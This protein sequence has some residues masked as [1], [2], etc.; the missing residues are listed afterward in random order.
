MKKTCEEWKEEE[1]QGKKGNS[2]FEN[3]EFKKKIEEF[4]TGG[5][6]LAKAQR[7]KS[8][9]QA[10]KIA[11]EALQ[12]IY[13][14]LKNC[15]ID[16]REL[17][18]KKFD[19]LF[20]VRQIVMAAGLGSRF[21]LLIH[22]ATA[23]GGIGKTNIELAMEGAFQSPTIVPVVIVNPKILGLV[24]KGEYLEGYSTETG[25]F[26]I[27]KDVL[28]QL[29]YQ[30][31]NSKSE[32][33]DKDLLIRYFGRANILLCYL[34][35]PLGP[36]GDLLEIAKI[37]C[38]KGYETPY[39]EVVYGEMSP[40]VLPEYTNTSLVAYLK[41]LSGDYVA[42]V[43]AKESQG[44]IE[45][46]GNFAF[47]NST[48]AAHED[49]ERIPHGYKNE[50][51]F[52]RVLEQHG[53]NYKIVKEKLTIMQKQHHQGKLDKQQLRE[54]V[55][56]L[57]ENYPYFVISDEGELFCQEKLKEV[58]DKLETW[59]EMSNEEKEYIKRNYAVTE[60]CTETGVTADLMI[61]ANVAIFETEVLAGFY[62][63]LMKE[64][65]EQGYKEYHESL[66]KGE[67]V[68]NRK[69][70]R[71]WGVD[72]KSGRSKAI[73]WSFSRIIKEWWSREHPGE[74]A[75]VALID[76][77]GAPSSIK[78]A[79]RQFEFTNRYNMVY[80]KKK[81][82]G[83][84]DSKWSQILL[85]RKKLEI[86]LCNVL[87]N[88]I[89]DYRKLINDLFLISKNNVK[90]QIIVLSTLK[91]IEE[92]LQNYNGKYPPEVIQGIHL[93][94]MVEAIDRDYFGP[95]LVVMDNK[96]KQIVLH[97]FSPLYTHPGARYIKDKLDRLFST[98]Q[99]KYDRDIDTKKFIDS[100]TN[101]TST[102]EQ[103]KVTH[104]VRPF[105]REKIKK[106]LE[107]TGRT[108]FVREG[109]FASIDINMGVDKAVA[110]TDF[111]KEKGISLESSIYF[112][113]EFDING[114][115]TPVTKL[116][117]NGKNSGFRVISVGLVPPADTVTGVKW[118]EGGPGHTKNILKSILKGLKSKKD[119]ITMNIK[120][121]EKKIYIEM[122]IDLKELKEK[123]GLIF[124]VDGTILPRKEYTFG[125]DEEIRNIFRTLLGEGIK[126]GIISGNSRI[127]QSSRI[128]HP[129]KEAGSNLEGLVLYANGGATR[130]AYE[131]GK[132]NVENLT[133]SVPQEDIEVI[134]DVVEEWAGEQFGL[135]T[136][137]LSAW[138]NFYGAG[139][140]GIGK[141]EKFPE[142][143]VS[144][145]IE[146]KWT[147][148]I[149]NVEDI[150]GEKV[151]RISCPWV[152]VRDGVQV[153]IKLLPRKLKIPRE[154]FQ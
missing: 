20:G 90:Q 14:T 149:V 69:V 122:K 102:P 72:W 145:M 7:S 48:L 110:L 67:L 11:K 79:E 26:E 95:E 93:N 1:Y 142:L 139:E 137:E 58:R 43:G 147:I 150:T 140:N 32:Y 144:W 9:D 97:Y 118:V 56:K 24:L 94:A 116:K 129:L 54:K 81:A 42:V 38:E 3:S 64:F 44:K 151:K 92:N 134:K 112:G 8:K 22:K 138:K 78:N 18:Q 130:A 106:A 111:V 53:N 104:D 135:S 15:G 31:I 114:N 16:W 51:E 85:S 105:L 63:E 86:K 10:K 35:V 127:E 12:G 148:D 83:E 89:N 2:T 107:S 153:S 40:S 80:E 28:E 121:D 62:D 49:W 13:C 103:R 39:I 33:I 19:N 60:K 115:D 29:E 41:I 119:I 77:T 68:D 82:T 98:A 109:G 141:R 5:K 108:Y 101:K 25:S 47:N 66:K 6:D 71:F 88:D 152:E 100:N 117:K 70:G 27:K 133:G 146:K 55:R 143:D 50:H 75:P 65:N 136:K 34:P 21:S 154:V 30:I 57:R 124:D 61:S 123:G 113:D 74:E 131:N 73:V 128:V 84:I 4:V 76:V 87:K 96:A 120:D 23:T 36:G 99:E 45:F 126:V 59:S 17:T 132:E 46:K 125:N 52:D 37:L 91:R